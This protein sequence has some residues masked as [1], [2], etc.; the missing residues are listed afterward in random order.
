MATVHEEDPRVA[1][2]GWETLP[3]EMRRKVL[4][5]RVS[6]RDL[7]SCLLAATSF[8]VLTE[9]DLEARQYA[10]A[11]V[12]GMCC[13]GDI[14]GLEY[15]LRHRPP[16]D[17]AV[18]WALCLYEADAL[19][20]AHTVA[21]ILEH[22]PPPPRAL[23][24]KS[25]PTLFA[26][27]DND[28]MTCHLF[29]F[30]CAFINMSD[31]YD[32]TRAESANARMRAM[33]SDASDAEVEA[34]LQ[35]TRSAGAACDFI[36]SSLRV[37]RQQKA[38]PSCADDVVRLDADYRW[39]RAAGD[40]EQADVLQRKL[41]DSFSEAT[42]VDALIDSDR[43]DEAVSLATN[44]A[45]LA[46]TPVPVA[47]SI[48]ARV[49]E[50][51][52]VRGRL[53]LIESLAG[54]A[55]NPTSPFDYNP[56]AF[57]IVRGAARG[58]HMSILEYAFERWP[59]VVYGESAIAHAVAG[60]HLDCVRWLCARGFACDKRKTWCPVR[61]ANVSAL[62]LAL[63]ARRKDMI[64]AMVDANGIDT[65]AQEAFDSAVA[66]GDMRSARTVCSIWPLVTTPTTTT[67]ARPLSCVPVVLAIE[68]AFAADP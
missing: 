64:D 62:T 57:K 35:K 25:L 43:L 41:A 17:D 53:A 55:D 4:L 20:H 27:V 12:E 52:A 9:R 31:T 66:I 24:W 7:G 50:A 14:K 3:T 51:C 21:W 32:R 23:V 33:L 67:T 34:A 54:T 11:T 61:C 37:P 15:V 47:S 44:S 56:L 2:C 10:Y 65:A 19:G 68:E 60:G 45:T 58:G 28:P 46:R 13:A 48:I 63:V 49:I 18:D 29:T 39:C 26:A 8:H 22:A 5:D 59:S 36:V 38:D 16:P 30:A 40:H 1:P 42:V 6:D